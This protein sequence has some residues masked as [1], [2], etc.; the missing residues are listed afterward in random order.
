[1]SDASDPQR[2]EPGDLVSVVTDD[3]GYGIVKLLVTDA[4]GV[5]AR[6]YQQRFTDRPS[7]VD[8]TTL[9]LG[10]SMFAQ[11]VPFS[12]GHIPLCYETFAHWQPVLLARGLAVEDREMQ[13]H[14]GWEEAEGGYF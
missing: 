10:P 9:S 1:M 4:I 7:A 13:G 3:G 11:D 6:L 14:R 8:P 12:I 2:F 5:H